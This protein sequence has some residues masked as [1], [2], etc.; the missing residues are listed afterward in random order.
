MSHGDAG[1]GDCDG[2]ALTLDGRRECVL[3]DDD[4]GVS[5]V[6]VDR[7]RWILH[8]NTANTMME[9]LKRG[10]GRRR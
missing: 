2:K 7:R 3:V 5:R 9:G 8:G 4:G 1:E 6:N 10:G